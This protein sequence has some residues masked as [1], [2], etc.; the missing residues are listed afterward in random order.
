MPCCSAHARSVASR[1][2]GG[3]R[4]FDCSLTSSRLIWRT[5][6]TDGLVVRAVATGSPPAPRLG[7]ENSVYVERPGR[8][9]P[10]AAGLTWLRCHRPCPATS[11]CRGLRQ[12]VSAG[13]RRAAPR[14][15]G[16]VSIHGAADD[17]HA[18]RSKQQQ[19]CGD[20]GWYRSSEAGPSIGLAPSRSFDQ[21]TS[22]VLSS[23]RCRRRA[24]TRRYLETVAGFDHRFRPRDHGVSSVHR[25]TLSSRLGRASALGT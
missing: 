18:R 20:S 9:A 17:E 24:V 8:K 7:F 21:S 25:P 2:D 22:S 5:S 11:A 23:C 14:D 4:N 3:C 10:E 1:R 15:A 16:S 13:A 12:R 19:S 6:L